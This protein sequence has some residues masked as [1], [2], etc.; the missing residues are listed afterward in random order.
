[1][2]LRVMCDGVGDLLLDFDCPER[3]VCV[4]II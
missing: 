4:E 2:L 1:M 3:G